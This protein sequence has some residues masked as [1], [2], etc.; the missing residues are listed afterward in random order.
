[1]TIPAVHDVVA[2]RVAASEAPDRLRWLVRDIANDVAAHGLND[3]A[4]S[5][6]TSRDSVL[7]AAEIE[8]MAG[9]RRVRAEFHPSRCKCDP[10]RVSARLRKIGKDPR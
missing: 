3:R 5:P 6:W 7:L 2:P 4:T 8:A 1:M 9:V 10:C